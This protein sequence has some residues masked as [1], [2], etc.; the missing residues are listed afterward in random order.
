[1]QRKWLI[2]LSTLLIFGVVNIGIWKS[3]K[4][5]EQG[6]VVLLEL[7][8]VDPRSLMQGDYMALRYTM[9]D[10]IS[11]QLTDTDTSI[12]GQVIVELDQQRRAK[13][14]GVDQQQ[15]LADGQLRLQFRLRHGQVKLATNA[16]FFQE[17]TGEIYESAKYGLF[18]VGQ[19]GNLLLT[20]LVDEQLHPLGQVKALQPAAQE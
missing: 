16:F 7:A 20:H 14:V 15:P 18:R 3:E 2:V 11:A 19:D 1:M 17:G 8:P 6:E 5:I 9:A 13:F 4:L 12:N 10:A